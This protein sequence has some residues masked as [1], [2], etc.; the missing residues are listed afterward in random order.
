MAIHITPRTQAVFG[1][2]EK[3]QPIV[4]LPADETL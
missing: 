3:T 1:V 4:G 2:P